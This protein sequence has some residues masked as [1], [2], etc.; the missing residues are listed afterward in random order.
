[1]NPITSKKTKPYTMI[2]IPANP[3]PTL[4]PNKIPETQDISGAMKRMVVIPQMRNF[5]FLVALR[6]KKTADIM[7]NTKMMIAIGIWFSS[8]LP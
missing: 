7:A 5:R 1:M 8:L 4:I 2:V 3:S 6:L